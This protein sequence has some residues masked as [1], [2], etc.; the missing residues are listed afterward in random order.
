MI[1]LNELVLV[2]P[3]TTCWHSVSFI[4][5][6]EVGCNLD[7]VSNDLF[8]RS[9]GKRREMS[10]LHGEATGKGKGGKGKGRGERSI[11]GTL[12]KWV[13]SLSMFN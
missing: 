6:G 13:I 8:I 12:G 3:L 7:S 4:I 1:V 9:W 10:L 5:N 11:R 2:K